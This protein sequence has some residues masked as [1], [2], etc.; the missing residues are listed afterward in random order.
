[1]KNVMF[2]INEKLSNIL[3]G[4][5]KELSPL[6]KNLFNKQLGQWIKD[7]IADLCIYDEKLNATIISDKVAMEI[8]E[9]F[10]MKW[11]YERSLKE[12][13]EY[14]NLKDGVQSVANVI[15]GIKW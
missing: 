2:L 13:K 12:L 3:S 5:E 7:P 9:L 15:R 4:V 8:Q 10:E 14:R 6:G 1:M 11:E